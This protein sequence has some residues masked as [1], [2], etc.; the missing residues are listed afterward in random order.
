MTQSSWKGWLRQP[1]NWVLLGFLVVAGY[2]AVLEHRAH[3]ALIAAVTLLA[4]CILMNRYM[5]R[6]PSHEIPPEPKGEQP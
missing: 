5:H 4:A 3:L 2:F 6:Q 1:R